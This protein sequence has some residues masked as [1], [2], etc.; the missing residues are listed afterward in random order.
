MATDFFK[1]GDTFEAFTQKH[2]PWRVDTGVIEDQIYENHL[3][4]TF[5]NRPKAGV[6][7]EVCHHY[8]NGKKFRGATLH[9]MENFYEIN[10]IL[11]KFNLKE[12]YSDEW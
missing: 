1:I 9:E 5:K 3:L 2:T 6:L 8:K 12:K 7:N 4:Y 11:K 10:N